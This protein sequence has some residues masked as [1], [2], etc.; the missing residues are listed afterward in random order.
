MDVV[1]FHLKGLKGLS[2]RNIAMGSITNGDDGNKDVSQK[3][4][5]HSQIKVLN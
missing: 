3:S 2:L 1:G 4:K 5:L